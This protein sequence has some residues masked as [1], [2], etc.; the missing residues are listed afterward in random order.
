MLDAGCGPGHNFEHFL[1]FGPS[2]KYRGEDYSE[3]FV[4]VA[5][6]R[7]KPMRIFSI[8]DVRK[9]RHLDDSFD[10]VIMQD[11]LEHTNGYETPVSEA[12][13]VARRLVIFT[14]WRLGNTDQIN[15]DGDDGYG[16]VYAKDKWEKFLDSLNLKWTHERLPRKDAYHDLYSVEVEH[17]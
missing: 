16:A 9:L 15:D 10:V 13:R 4:R 14:F 3:R 2:V 12:L 17:G 11:V 6:Q 5:N 7:V 8:G 1:E